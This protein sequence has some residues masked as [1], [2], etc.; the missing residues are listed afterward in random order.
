MASKAHMAAAFGSEVKCKAGPTFIPAL[1]AHERVFACAA[2][3]HA[4]GVAIANSMRVWD[5]E[6]HGL[7]ALLTSTGYQQAVTR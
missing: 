1:S 6:S 5:R 4:A 7:E 3:D 2:S